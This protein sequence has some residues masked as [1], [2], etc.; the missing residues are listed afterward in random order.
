MYINDWEFVRL[1]PVFFHFFVQ[2]RT[3]DPQFPGSV[4]H[5]S[6]AVPQGCLYDVPFV[7]LEIKLI[8]R[9]CSYI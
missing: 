5:I 3:I 7:F 1:N 6:G 8:F 4:A 2:R 9:Y